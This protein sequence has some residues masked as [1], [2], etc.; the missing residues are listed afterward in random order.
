MW[1]FSTCLDILKQFDASP[2]NIQDGGKCN[3]M[4]FPCQRRRTFKFIGF[5]VYKDHA[6]Y[7]IDNIFLTLRPKEIFGLYIS[8]F[9]TKYSAKVFAT[10]SSCDAVETHHKQTRF[11]LL[12]I[13][14]H[15]EASLE[16]FPP[17]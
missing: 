6:S 11:F 7:W 1:I 2:T 10:F 3:T 5:Q 12:R 15:T 14:F 4:L 16:M 9:G 17:L 13:L 8:P